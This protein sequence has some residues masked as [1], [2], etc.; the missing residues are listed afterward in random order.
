MKVIRRV[1]KADYIENQTI[2]IT[3]GDSGGTDTDTIENLPKVAD[4]AI[5][6]ELDDGSIVVL[7]GYLRK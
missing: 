2:S 7:L 3:I 1:D 5:E 6:V 4:T